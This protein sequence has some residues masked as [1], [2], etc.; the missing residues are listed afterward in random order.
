MKIVTTKDLI[1]MNSIQVNQTKVVSQHL[2][3]EGLNKS[4]LE[5]EKQ[6]LLS[7]LLKENTE[8]IKV[9][10]QYPINDIQDIELEVDFIVIKREDLDKIFN[11]Y[12]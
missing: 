3:N 9:T 6:H 8:L 7:S 4:N 1:L 5:K 11:I 10:E 12:N 2:Y